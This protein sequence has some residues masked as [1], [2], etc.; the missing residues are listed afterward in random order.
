M[1]SDGNESFSLY[2]IDISKNKSKIVLLV[3]STVGISGISSATVVHTLPED[4][5]NIIVQYNGRKIKAADLYKLPLSSRWNTKRNK[6][7]K[8]KLVAKNLGNVQRWLLDN[9]GYVGGS[10]T[11]NGLEGKFL[12]KEQGVKEFKVLQEFN[13]L[14]EGFSPISFDFDDKTLFV[15]SN[16]G[17][18]RAAI[19]KYSPEKNKLGEMVFGHDE[20]DVT[21]LIMSRHQ[22]KLLGV[23]LLM[24]TLSLFI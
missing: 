19:Y 9:A 4:P 22:K 7:N 24:N 18:D 3:G 17:R 13:P 23:I 14:D 20:V 10:T 8:M 2:K 21:G 5:D 16:I 15:S 6:N 11:L 12:Y 1:D